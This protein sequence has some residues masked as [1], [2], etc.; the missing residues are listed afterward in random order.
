M[1]ISRVTRAPLSEVIKNFDAQPDPRETGSKI[2]K[3]VAAIRPTPKITTRAKGKH[4]PSNHFATPPDF[5]KDI[6]A[7]PTQEINQPRFSRLP[8][9]N[10]NLHHQKILR[11]K[12]D[13]RK[14]KLMV[15]HNPQVDNTKNSNNN[16]VGEVS[17]GAIKMQGKMTLEELR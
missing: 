13:L 15:I 5:V 11:K 12:D 8:I 17:L 4:Q 3:E 16:N 14:E 7:E 1:G 2:E 10:N 9:N 6:P